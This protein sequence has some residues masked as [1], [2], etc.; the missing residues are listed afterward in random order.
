MSKKNKEKKLSTKNY[1]NV[2]L[3]RTGNH[4]LIYYLLEERINNIHNVPGSST[5][6][7]K[8]Y[9]KLFSKKDIDII[10]SEK[11]SNKWYHEHCSVN[12]HVHRQELGIRSR[13]LHGRHLYGVE[14]NWLSR[15]LPLKLKVPKRFPKTLSEH[16]TAYTVQID[17]E[18]KLDKDLLKCAKMVDENV[19]KIDYLRE[20]LWNVLSCFHFTNALIAAFPEFEP[21]IVKAYE[22]KEVECKR[23]AKYKPNISSAEYPDLIKELGLFKKKRKSKGKKFD[24][25]NHK[26]N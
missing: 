9:N 20:R 21:Y 13:F 11:L 2:R 26:N 14:N 23:V 22:L 17:P 19:I 5:L 10:N 24:N 6:A 25:I 8:V 7:G 4:P 3:N 18:T 12:V 16:R 1:V 15:F